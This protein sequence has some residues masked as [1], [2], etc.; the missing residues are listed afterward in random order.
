MTPLT[1]HR[2][3]AAAVAA[4]GAAV[5]LAN[6]VDPDESRALGAC[7]LALGALGVALPDPPGDGARPAAR[8]A[9]AVHRALELAAVLLLVLAGGEWTVRREN[10]IAQRAYEGRLMRFVDDPVLR[11]EMQPD[12]SCGEGATNA[13]GMFDPPRELAK[14]ENTLRVACLGDSVGGDCSLPR[15][16]ACAA[17]ERILTEARGG[18]PTE[19][20]NFS[21]PG[22]STLQE[23]RALEQKA[24]PFAPD[25]VVVL[26]VINDPYP[27][28]AIS[29]FI[30]GH[31]KF[32]HLLWSGARLA[33]WRLVSPSIDPFGGLF[34]EL[35]DSPRSWD[36]VVVA[37][38]DRIRAAAAGAPVAVAVFPMFIDPLPPG[39]PAIYA[40]VAREAERHGFLGVDL[41]EA[42]YRGEPLDALLKPSRDIIHP[43]ARAHRLAAEAIARALLARHPELAAR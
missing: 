15:D 25:A 26:Y 35:H 7:L 37:G 23:A 4:A 43:N 40:K 3:L 19:V 5:V 16:N 28:L 12:V 22:Y 18:R 32:Q 14:P 39:Y 41:S 13:L 36:G 9:R 27:D 1:P 21:V 17:L 29:H 8:A 6:R 33:A 38:L 11:Y 34:Q 30:P 2:A 42:A 24:L 20:L 31:F 10:G